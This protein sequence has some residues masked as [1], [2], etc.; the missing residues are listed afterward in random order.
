MTVMSVCVFEKDRG[1]GLEGEVGFLVSVGS[2][3]RIPANT[4]QPEDTGR[5]IQVTTV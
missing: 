4:L 2:C 5:R 1:C 3:W